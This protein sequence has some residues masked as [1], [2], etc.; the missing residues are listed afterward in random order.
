MQSLTALATILSRY[1]V[2]PAPTSLRRPILDPSA[3]VVQTII[4]GLP[5]IFTPRT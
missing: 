2:S 3:N 1:S 5:L 4:G